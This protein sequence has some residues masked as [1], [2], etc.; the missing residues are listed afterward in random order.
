MKLETL[1]LRIVVF[2]LGIPVLALCIFLVPEMAKLAAEMLPDFPLAGVL[3]GAIFYASAIP[4]YYALLQAYNLLRWI[5]GNTAF[6]DQSV[7]ALKRIKYCAIIISVLHT[8]AL[9]FFYMYAELDDAPGV[10]IIG[11]IVPFA[12]LVIAVFAAVLQKL[13]QHAIDIKSEND[14]T[15]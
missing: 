5:D 7:L 14:L 13:L 11:C 8:L 12:S 1:F 6:S 9:P 2:L 3:V 4:Y 15:I 10:V